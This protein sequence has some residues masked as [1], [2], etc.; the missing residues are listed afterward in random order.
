MC[1]PEASRNVGR[2][3]LGAP[4]TDRGQQQGPVPSV[5]CLPEKAGPRAARDVTAKASTHQWANQAKRGLDGAFSITAR[6]SLPLRPRKQAMSHVG[7]RKSLP[8][9]SEQPSERALWGYFNSF[10]MGKPGRPRG[11]SRWRG[12]GK[13]GAIPGQR[14]RGPLGPPSPS[15]P[16]AALGSEPLPSGSFFGGQSGAL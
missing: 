11:F 13:A 2:G 7:C 12:S 8:Q 15:S 4:G 14:Q 10:W 9:R 5:L 1:A 16:A 3:G 6:I